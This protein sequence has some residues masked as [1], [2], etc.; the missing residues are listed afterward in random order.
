MFDCGVVLPESVQTAISPESR[1]SRPAVQVRRQEC[2]H[3]SS[4]L[5]RVDE[6]EP[7]SA[8]Q[9][10][11]GEGELGVMPFA[12]EGTDTGFKQGPRVPGR[13]PVTTNTGE[14]HVMDLERQIR[15]HSEVNRDHLNVNMA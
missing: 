3:F 9:R 5:L 6:V 13:R 7:P 8:C 15:P 11:D 10:S 1:H 14:R 12:T 2:S 4:C